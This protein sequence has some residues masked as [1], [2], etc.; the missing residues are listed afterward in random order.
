MPSWSEGS[1]TAAVYGLLLVVGR[2]FSL[3]LFMLRRLKSMSTQLGA[4]RHGT[5][6]ASH[7][8]LHIHGLNESAQVVR[9]DFSSVEKTIQMSVTYFYPHE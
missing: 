2:C 6:T 3:L 9:V 1:A 5:L 8:L 4:V 7:C